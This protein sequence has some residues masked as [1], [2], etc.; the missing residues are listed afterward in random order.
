MPDP[1]EIHQLGQRGFNCPF[2]GDLHASLELARFKSDADCV[3]LHLTYY[4]GHPPP[5]QIYFQVAG[6]RREIFFSPASARAGIVTCGGLCPGLNNVIRSIFLELH[7]HYRVSS[8]LG[9]Q[10]G[11]HGLNPASGYPPIELD[12]SVVSDI[13]D[14]KSVV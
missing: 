6:P 14:R 11:Y 12:K 8:I 4:E 2:A 10:Y 9:F 7:Y 5:D 13:Q 3:P 1:V